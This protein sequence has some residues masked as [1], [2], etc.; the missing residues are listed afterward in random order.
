M[1]KTLLLSVLIAA[2]VTLMA[3]EQKEVMTGASYMDEVFYS[4]DSGTVETVLRPTWDLG[5][6]TSNFSVSILAN[7][8][9]GVE[10]YTYPLGDTAD[11]ETVDTTGMIWTPMYNSLETFD[12]GALS[13]NAL[14]HPDYG[15][16]IYNELSHNITGDSLFVIKTLAGVYKKLA[17]IK[18]GSMANTWEFKFANLDS[19]D[20]Q[21]VLLNSGEYNS[22][23]FVYYSLDN[24]AILDREPPTANWDMLFTKY[25]GM[26]QMGPGAP[27]PYPV[28]G[29]LTNDD[30]VVVQEVREEGLD[31]ATFVEYQDTAFSSNISLIGSDWKSFNMGEGKYEIDTTVV[32]F[33]KKYEET[34]SNGMKAAGTDST[35]Y[36]IY[37]TGFDMSMGLYTF[38]QEKLTAVSTRNPGVIQMLQVYPNPASEYINVV[39][40]YTGETAIQIIDMTG[41]TVQST[42][43]NAGGFTSLSLD[44]ARLNPGLFFLRVNTGDETGVLRFIKE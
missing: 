39:F 20:E 6:T 1:K 30:H 24:N 42:I 43:H 31:Q 35:Y 22:K 10:V 3:Q 19:T 9:A 33:L 13:A 21:S 36:K 34:E 29:I 17:I 7:T 40:D 2:A 16:G 28:S 14:G 25:T 38:I 44:I 5:F 18:R 26:I 27:V 37:F 32:Y 15:W 8:A 4:L 23:N 12:E 11:W 41:R